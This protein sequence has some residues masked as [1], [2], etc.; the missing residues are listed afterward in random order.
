MQFNPD[1]NKQAQEVYFSKKSNHENSLAVTFNNA[2]V[3]TCST[4][5]YLGLLLD[6]RFGFN[7]HIQTKMS[8][9][10][11]MTEVINRLSVILPAM[12]Y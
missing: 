2:K 3:G 4:H 11:K 9:Y 8:K 7:E 1:P 6:T 12:R 5:K 10:Y